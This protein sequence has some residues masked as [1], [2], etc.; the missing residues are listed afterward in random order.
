MKFPT[1]NN[2]G[3]GTELGSVSQ[4]TWGTE[5]CLE[6]HYSVAEIAQLW[7]VSS[8]TV[9]SVFKDEPGIIEFGHE[10]FLHK[11]GYKTIRVPES[12][13]RRVHARLKKKAK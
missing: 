12:V 2:S 1:S 5:A 3:L 8:N 11:R 10:E 4:Q 13:L 6:R 9:R 7:N